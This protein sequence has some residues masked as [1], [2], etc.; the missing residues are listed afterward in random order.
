MSQ[1]LEVW[2]DSDLGPMVRVGSLSHDRGQVRFVY[3]KGWLQDPRAFALDPDL[4]LGA[5]SY[6]P[7]PELGNFGVFLDS[8]PD[9][10]GQTLMKRREALLAKDEARKPRNLYAWDYLIGV[11]DFTRQGALRFRLEGD[12]TYLGAEKLAAPPV[13][14]LHELQV[15]ATQLTGKKL[16]DLDALRQWL[17]VLVAPGA[18][19]GGARPKANFTES[20]GALWIGKFP[21]RDDDRDMAGW[22]Y[23][24]YRLAQQSGITVPEARLLSLDKDYR[25]L[26]VKRFDR[27]GERRRFYASA[28][29]LLRKEHSEGTSYLEMA[30]FL[31]S[32]GDGP[33]VSA[34]LEQLFRRLAFN[35][36]IGNRDD[37]L[38]NHG[39][40]LGA[41]GWRLSPAFDMN[42]NIDKA[43]HVLN[44]DDT[45]N[46]PDLKTVIATA[47]FYGLDAPRARAIVAEVLQ[48]VRQWREMAS[49]LQLSRADI[50]LMEAAFQA[51]ETCR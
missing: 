3:D 44:I 30:Q 26:C 48:A 10:W 6:F 1:T 35:V 36:A 51:S 42:P 7:N 37:H 45:D 22:E 47:A 5:Q 25:T 13:T 19:L 29:T 20:D 28:M 31:R 38:R 33:H 40:I 14:S 18:S 8:S 32:Q 12:E 11:Q 21:A 39:F 41:N 27:V 9:R 46:R 34:D 43:D 17:A 2:L 50:L 49:S 16:D 23:L 24:A 15:V 4:S